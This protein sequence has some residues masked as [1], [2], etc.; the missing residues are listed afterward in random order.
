MK[1][2]KN[3]NNSSFSLP[4][5]SRGDGCGEVEEE[6]EE[7]S[8]CK[9]KS[10]FVEFGFLLCGW[11]WAGPP[12]NAPQRRETSENKQTQLQSFLL[13]FNL[14]YFIHSTPFLLI[15]QIKRNW[16]LKNE[17]NGIQS[18]NKVKS[19]K[20]WIGMKWKGISLWLSGWRWLMDEMEQQWAAWLFFVVGYR[21]LAAIMLRKEEES[22]LLPQ[23]YSQ[24]FFL[25]QLLFSF[26]FN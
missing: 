14:S 10:W 22:W 18:T 26:H 6:E 3:S 8:R 11:L 4:F 13:S 20:K 9:R 19:K 16:E 15:Q 2:K 23:L 1:L 17:W 24:L 12:A 21:R 25:I 7:K 5:N